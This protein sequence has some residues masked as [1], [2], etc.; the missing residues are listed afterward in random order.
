MKTKT[1][2]K[3]ET[4]RFLGREVSVERAMRP[5]G[6][7]VVR[8]LRIRITVCHAPLTRALV[9]INGVYGSIPAHAAKSPQSAASA[10]ERDVRKLLATLVRACG[11]EGW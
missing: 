2:P 6:A 7:L 3:I 1:K 9:S 4:V 8:G 10:V 11:E 5:E